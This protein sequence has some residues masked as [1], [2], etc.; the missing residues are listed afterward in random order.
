[1]M[2]GNV[3]LATG[4]GKDPEDW[5]LRIFTERS[6]PWEQ[7]RDGETDESPIVNVWYDNSFFDKSKSNVVSEQVSD[8]VYNI[9]I[10]GYGVSSDDGAGH[11]PGDKEAA[12]E[13]QKA[14]RLVR[15]ILMASENTYLQLRGLVWE[16]WPQSITSFQPQQSENSVEKIVAARIAFGVRFTELAPQY[17]GEPLE[18][19]TTTVKRREDGSIYFTAEYD[20]TT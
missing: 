11:K 18:L 2:T 9:D 20:Y 17:V 5:K 1:M 4:A 8:T 13:C 15:N 10:Y 19:L 7:F 3:P 16:R 12:L 6:N 14:I